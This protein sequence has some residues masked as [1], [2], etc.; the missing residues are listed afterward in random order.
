MVVIRH[1]YGD[2]HRGGTED[3]ENDTAEPGNVNSSL[4]LPFQ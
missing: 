2:F 1:G 3:T 4:P